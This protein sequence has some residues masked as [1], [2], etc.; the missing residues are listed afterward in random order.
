MKMKPFNDDLEQ[1]RQEYLAAK[2]KPAKV[3]PIFFDDPDQLMK[4]S[5]AYVIT[6]LLARR[7]R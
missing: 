6:S 7:H 5:T 2:D 1:K 3:A 4:P